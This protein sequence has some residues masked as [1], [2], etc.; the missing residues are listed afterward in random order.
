ME[1]GFFGIGNENWGCGGN[2]NPEYY[3]NEY[4]RYQTYVRNYYPEHPIQKICCGA[5][6][7]DYQ[8]TSEVLKTTFSHCL[9]ELHGNMNGLSSL[10]CIS[11][12]TGKERKLYGF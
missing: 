10:L 6:A 4:R 11:G 9:E 3:A 5:N 8:W 2:M 12:W 7:D 1:T